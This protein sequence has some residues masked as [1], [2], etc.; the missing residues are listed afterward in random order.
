MRLR[1]QGLAIRVAGRLLLRDLNLS[2]PPGRSLAITGPSGSGKTTLLNCLCGIRLPDEGSVLI[3]DVAV[4]ALSHASRT[5]FRLRNCGMVFQSGELVQELTVGDNVMLP[6]IMDGIKEKVA[7]EPARRVLSRLGI[8][9][10]EG[11]YPEALSGGETQRVAVARALVRSPKVVFADEPTG[12]LD[13]TN[14]YAVMCLLLEA[15]TENSASVVIVTHDRVVAEMAH[16]VIALGGAL[17][18]QDQASANSRA[19]Q[20]RA[21]VG[22][23]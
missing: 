17:T 4:N 11:R 16:Q 13:E 1:T 15:A 12:A 7:R 14:S 9:E 3:D 5:R 23:C 10:L 18:M 21:E 2:L 6:M 22:G 19:P 20:S 8:G